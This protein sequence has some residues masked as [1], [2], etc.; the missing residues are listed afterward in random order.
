MNIYFQQFV[1]SDYNT[2]NRCIGKSGTFDF[3]EGLDLY[4]WAQTNLLPVRLAKLFLKNAGRKKNKTR[5][6]GL[7]YQKKYTVKFICRPIVSIIGQSV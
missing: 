4:V 5:S 6:V 3:A 1:T 2:G 7:S